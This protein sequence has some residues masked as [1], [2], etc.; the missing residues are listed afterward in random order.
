MFFIKKIENW[1]EWKLEAG[2]IFYPGKNTKIVFKIRQTVQK[3]GYRHPGQKEFDDYK[4]NFV[5]PNLI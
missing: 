3:T 5:P 2:H 1:L 4:A